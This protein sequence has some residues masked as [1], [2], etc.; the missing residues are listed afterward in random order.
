MD[1]DVMYN[2]IAQ[3]VSKNSQ[4]DEESV[5]KTVLCTKIKKKNAWNGKDY[6][7]NVVSFENMGVFGLVMIRMKIP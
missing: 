5:I 1:D 4:S 3:A 6:E 7:K 2:K